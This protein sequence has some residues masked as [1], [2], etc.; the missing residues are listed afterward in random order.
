MFS[1]KF[2]I[3]EFTKTAI[4]SYDSQIENINLILNKYLYFLDLKDKESLSFDKI[5]SFLPLIKDDNI[6]EMVLGKVGVSYNERKDGLKRYRN[7]FKNNLYSKIKQECLDKINQRQEAAS[8][9]KFSFKTNSRLIVGFGSASVLETSIKLHHIYGVPYIPSSAI[10][11]ILKAYRI[12]KLAD[13]EENKFTEIEEDLEKET[14]NEENKKIIEIFGNQYQQGK[15]TVFDS[16][17]ENFVGFDVDIMNPHFP[18]YYKGEDPPTDW[19][20]PTPIT[21]LTIPK[22][23]TFRFFFK[24]SSLY[25]KSFENSLKQDLQDALEY[26]GIGGKTSIGY[27]I[28]GP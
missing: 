10:K 4:E 13:W 24:N 28:L 11:G 16:Y 7:K 12:W 14:N 17:P 6:F 27:G 20:N 3:P 1:R 15:L 26:I 22:G 18:N 5:L 21:F 9:L 2:A 19:Q 23:V 25:E 8:D